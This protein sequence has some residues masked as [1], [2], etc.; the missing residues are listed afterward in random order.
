[1]LETHLPSL[2][3]SRGQ[4]GEGK[5]LAWPADSGLSMPVSS[6]HWP[7][8]ASSSV[9]SH[10]AG[11]CAGYPHSRGSARGPSEG[12]LVYGGQCRGV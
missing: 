2:L 7:L 11:I 1:M 5:M 9:H 12:L 6:R 10:L 3:K 8:L 4:A